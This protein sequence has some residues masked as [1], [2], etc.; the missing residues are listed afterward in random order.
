MY[1]TRKLAE[2]ET[3]RDMRAKPSLAEPGIS[4]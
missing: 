2:E 3:Y 4:L 1:N